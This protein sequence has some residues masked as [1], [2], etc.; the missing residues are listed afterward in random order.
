MKRIS[1]T[2]E[3]NF[4]KNLTKLGNVSGHMSTLVHTHTLTLYVLHKKNCKNAYIR[5]F[6]FF[7]TN[8]LAIVL[9]SP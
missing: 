2:S 5:D 4:Q 8:V 1:S 7:S 3:S 6:S 9:L